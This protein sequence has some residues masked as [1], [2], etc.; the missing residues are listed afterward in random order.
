[1]IESI[2][3]MEYK[4]MIFNWLPFPNFE[5]DKPL[6]LKEYTHHWSN[7]SATPL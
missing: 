6:V 5:V 2:D 3:S 1:V 4:Y 7:G